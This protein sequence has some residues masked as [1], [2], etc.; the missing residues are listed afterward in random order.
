M[1]INKYERMNKE[2]I[3]KRIGQFQNDNIAEKWEIKK[4]QNWTDVKWN[5]GNITGKKLTEI[6]RSPRISLK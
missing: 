1:N 4:R 6:N 2:Q 3:E 5:N